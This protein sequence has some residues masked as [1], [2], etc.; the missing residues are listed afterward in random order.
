MARAIND[1]N[2]VRMATGMGLVALTD[3]IVL[4]LAAIGFMMSLDIHLTI[5]SLIP[6]PFIIIF[7]R[8]LTK[9]MSFGFESVQRSF[10]DLTER[11]REIF[12]G[13]RVIKAY[14]RETWAYQRVEDEGLNYVSENM[15]LAKTLG[16]FFPLMA[17]FTN[18]GLCV[19]IWLGG[20][21][22]ILGNISTGDFVAFISYLNLLTWPI[23]A[24]GWVTNL[25]QRGS[26]SMLRINQI[27]E[28]VPEISDTPA[29]MD[30]SDIQGDIE[31]KDLNFRYP[32]QKD[33]ALKDIC[34]SVPS[35]ETLAVVGR[36]G[37][38]KTT[39]L[40]TIPRLVN[41]PKGTVFV[42]GKDV[43]LATL[44]TLRRNVG[45]VTQEVFLFSDTIRNNIVFGKTEVSDGKLEEVLHASDIYNDIQTFSKGLNTMLGERGLTLSGG[46]RQRLTIARALIID[47]AILILDDALSMVDTRTEEKILNRILKLRSNRTN[48]IV[49]HRVSTI[50]RA[51][52]I[53]M[54]EYGRLI[55][56]GTHEDLLKL[57]G[58][59]AAL[60][61]KQLIALE[62]ET[63]VK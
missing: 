51:N 56:Q 11:I 31:F 3:G 9:R 32:G 2:A 22:A 18:A 45:L 49:S 25:L 10:S 58:E 27:L 17:I 34:F 52:R 41:I 20:R 8:I 12:A 33:Y 43:C 55:E 60:Y 13:I 26:A 62:L 36:V 46:Q 37:S 57:G 30:L 6:A 40:N 1:I 7:T 5:I 53:I 24:M 29:A 23:M 59:Y 28:E 61:E 35:G 19:V 48:I 39:L 44:K 54:L 14:D 63:G 47:P 21:L 15:D 50:N 42:D 38:G 4:G 16:L